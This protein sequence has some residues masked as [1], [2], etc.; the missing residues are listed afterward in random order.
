MINNSELMMIIVIDIIV[1]VL[2]C[3]ITYIISEISQREIK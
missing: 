1:M 3:D 2:K